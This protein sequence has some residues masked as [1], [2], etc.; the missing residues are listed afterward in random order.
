M[1]QEHLGHTVDR[2]VDSDSG[3]SKS[4]YPFNKQKKT[5]HRTPEHLRLH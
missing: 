2:V 1:C 5:L 4:G 3:G